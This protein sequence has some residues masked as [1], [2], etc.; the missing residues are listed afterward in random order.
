MKFQKRGDGTQDSTPAPEESKSGRQKPVFIYIIILF[1]VA[2]VLLMISFIQH[3][4][5]NQ[6][7]LG[8]LHNSVNAIE[9]L[10]EA[11]DEN[12]KL[13]KELEKAQEELE[14]TKALLEKAQESQDASEEAAALLLLY[15]LQQEYAAGQYDAC[16]ETIAQMEEGGSVEALPDEPLNDTVVSPA[17]RFRQLKEAVE[18]KASQPAA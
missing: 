4:R 12:L 13:Q 8:E 1:T 9:E 15:E 16:K 3:Q 10:Q 6:Q 17:Q 7:V 11:T 5:S 14:E 18:Q 2:F